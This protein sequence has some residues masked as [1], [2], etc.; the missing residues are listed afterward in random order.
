MSSEGGGAPVFMQQ[1]NTLSAFRELQQRLEP[2]A[3]ATTA[4]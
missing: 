3:T 1:V 2:P 4:S